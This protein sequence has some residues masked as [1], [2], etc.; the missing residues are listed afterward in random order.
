MQAKIALKYKEK[1]KEK[2]IMDSVPTK[3]IKIGKL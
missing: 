2:Y 3:L 1:Y